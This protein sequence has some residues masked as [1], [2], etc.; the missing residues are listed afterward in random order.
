MTIHLARQQ[1]TNCLSR[2]V[3]GTSNGSVIPRDDGAAGE[4]T[5]KISITLFQVR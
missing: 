5:D 2:V 1:I 4:E 3:E